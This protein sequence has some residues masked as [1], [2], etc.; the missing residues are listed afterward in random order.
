MLRGAGW[1]AGAQHHEN[2][3]KGAVGLSRYYPVL[4]VL[5]AT[6]MRR[7]ECLAL[8]WDTVDLD[9]GTARIVATVGAVGG[10][11]LFST[12]KTARSRRTVPLPPQ[13]VALLRRHKRVQAE[14]RLRAG[15][16]WQNSNLVFTTE[17]GAPVNGK[18]ILAAVKAAAKTAGLEGG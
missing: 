11:L 18:S 4:A 12:P 1:P 9:A 17:L 3:P 14:E 8:S 5:A 15:N 10:E 2:Q 7:G 6:G 16:Q 13:V